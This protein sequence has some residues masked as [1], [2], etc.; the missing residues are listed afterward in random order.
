MR[1]SVVVVMFLAASVGPVI[2]TFECLSKYH[3][4]VTSYDKFQSFPWE[5]HVVNIMPDMI[6]G[7]NRTFR[8]RSTMKFER[9]EGL[10]C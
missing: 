1:V 6:R 10:I 8:C 2:L 4:W 7:G 9:R 3:S 5:I